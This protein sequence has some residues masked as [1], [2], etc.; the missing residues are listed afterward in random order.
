MYYYDILSALVTSSFISP[1]VTFMDLNVIY[2]QVTNNNN[3]FEYLRKFVK[4]HNGIK[5]HFVMYNVYASTYAVAN[6][7][8]TYCKN[9]NI[10]YKIPT[11]LTT[12]TVNISMIAYKDQLYTKWILNSSRHFLIKSYALFGIRDSITI[13][14]NFILKNDVIKYFER[15]MSTDKS[16]F[17]ASIMVPTSAQLIS[18]PLH[19]LA[20]DLYQ[21]PNNKLH[22]RYDNIKNMYTNICRGRIIRVIPAFCLGGFINDAILKY[23]KKVK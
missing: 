5:S 17:C 23:I 2:S 4:S 9:N 19:I 6:T 15:Y 18:T 16:N 13:F 22:E 11:L 20:I 10:D 8:S 21:N 14:S 12:T 1:I 3:K 7:T